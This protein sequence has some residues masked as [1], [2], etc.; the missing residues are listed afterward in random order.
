MTAN[1]WFLP[2]FSVF[3]GLLCL[4]AFWAGG[5]PDDGVFALGLMTAIGVLVLVGGRSEMIRGLR[6]LAVI[7]GMCLWE[8]GHGRDGSPY[9]AL[10]AIAGVAYL[11]G[12]AISRLRS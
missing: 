2:G 10:G 12:L 3:L 5:N 9:T 11:V 6:G 7:I 8:W 4:A 1:K